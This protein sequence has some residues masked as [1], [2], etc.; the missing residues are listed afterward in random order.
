MRTQDVCNDVDSR[1]ISQTDKR[2]VDICLGLALACPHQSD[3]VVVMALKAHPLTK[4]KRGTRHWIRDHGADIA[5]RRDR[6][7]HPQHYPLR[8]KAFSHFVEEGEEAA[9]DSPETGPEEYR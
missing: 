2:S 5:Q 9:F 3:P 7:H 1:A 8:S 6:D 4:H